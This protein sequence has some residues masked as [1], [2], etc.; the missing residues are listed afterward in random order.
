MSNRPA[1]NDIL[2]V[3]AARFQVTV[4]SLTRRTLGRPASNVPRK[5]AMY[6]CQ[7]LGD[8]RLQDIA[9]TFGLTH[10]G[11]VSPAVQAMKA[12]LEVGELQAEFNQVR[13]DLGIMKLT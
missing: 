13:E 9:R 7:Q 8:M 1:V 4:P 10:E 2:Q 11:S 3:V 6:C 12:G 5:F